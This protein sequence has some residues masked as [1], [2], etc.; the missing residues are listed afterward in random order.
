MSNAIL[1]SFDNTKTD[2]S[3]MKMTYGLMRKLNGRMLLS[4]GKTQGSR[5]A[6]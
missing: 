2:H 4:N 1:F 6:K 5:E 3:N